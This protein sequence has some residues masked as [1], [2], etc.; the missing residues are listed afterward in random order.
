M[1]LRSGR[2]RSGALEAWITGTVPLFPLRG[3]VDLWLCRF[4]VGG[5]CKSSVKTRDSLIIERLDTFSICS[6][7][8]SVHMPSILEEQIRLLPSVPSV[9]DNRGMRLDLNSPANLDRFPAQPCTRRRH[10]GLCLPI[11]HLPSRTGCS[12]CYIFYC[13]DPSLGR[14]CHS[15]C[16]ASAGLYHP[17]IRSRSSLAL[18]VGG[19][20]AIL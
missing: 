6:H 13:I 14:H 17:K 7:K 9:E 19:R 15:T 3:L 8:S 5:V 11:G 4:G 20:V 12:S 16:G 1:T 18:Y 2:S 10:Y